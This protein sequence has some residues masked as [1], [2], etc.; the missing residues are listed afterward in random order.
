MKKILIYTD[1]SCKQNPGY[2]GWAAILFVQGYKKKIFGNY[3]ICTNNQM[4]LLSTIN[5]IKYI[6]KPSCIKIITDS[7][8]VKEGINNWIYL[9]KHNNLVQ[10]DDIKKNKKLWKKLHNI[11][12]KK[13][14]IIQWY[15]I[16]SHNINQYNIKTDYLSKKVVGNE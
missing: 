3:S 16:K 7:Q 4:E 8:Y 9:W 14:H 11:F 10:T 5:S 2:G 15:W 13:K 12:I 6:G 1:G